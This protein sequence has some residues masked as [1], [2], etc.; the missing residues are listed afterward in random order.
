MINFTI[1]WQVRCQDCDI[2]IVDAPTPDS[3]KSLAVQHLNFEDVEGEKVTY[4]NWKHKVVIT[5]VEVV[6]HDS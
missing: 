5:Q 6:G 1:T 2:S 4:P 3:A